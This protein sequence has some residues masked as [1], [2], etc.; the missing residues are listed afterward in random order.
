[1]FNHDFVD[2]FFHM[3][4]ALTRHDYNDKSEVLKDFNRENL[5]DNMYQMGLFVL[6]LEAN[7]DSFMNLRNL[8]GKL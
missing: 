3:C 5:L 2:L 1:M 8:K 7:Y 6:V 4:N